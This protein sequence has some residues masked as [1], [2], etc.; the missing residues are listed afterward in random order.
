MESKFDTAP[1][2]SL[3][4]NRRGISYGIVQPGSHDPNGT[5]IVRVTDVRDGRVNTDQPLKVKKEIAGKYS[6]TTLRGGEL[7]LTLVGT[8]GELAI[9][10]ETMAG[11]NTARAVAVIPVLDDPGATWVKYA[12]EAGPAREYIKSRLN[13]TVQATLNLRDVSAFPVPLPSKLYRDFVIDVLDP[14]DKK[15][16]INRGL[17]MSLEECAQAIFKSWFIDFDP[18]V[19]NA[20]QAGYSVPE[21]FQAAAARYRDNPG[22]M[23]LPRHILELFPDRFEDSELGAIPSGWAV[24]SLASLVELIG[25]GTPKTKMPEYWGG[26]IPWFSVVDAPNE[27]DLW[28][29]DTEKHITEMGLENSSAKILPEET[30]IISARGTVGKC[31]LVGEPMAMNQSCYGVRP[32]SGYGAF[33]INFLLRKKID[34]LQQSGHGSVFN[35]ITRSTF[36]AIKV[37][38]CGPELSGFFDEQ[39]D[40]L[41]YGLLNRIRENATL[42]GMRDTLL[43]KLISGE[44]RIPEAEKLAAEAV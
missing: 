4:D 12:L 28:V 35:T 24:K 27:S 36:E 3:V 40:P 13:T 15:I 22:L 33:F 25:G 19:Y 34:Y 32:I 8:V 30:T 44:L 9:V 16:D 14:I 31:A 2:S 39:V 37:V 10:P 26:K 21:R 6:R 41:L 29:V 23:K 7:L 20:V 1:L 43:P 17:N 42:A 11:W 38:D 5:P 18:V